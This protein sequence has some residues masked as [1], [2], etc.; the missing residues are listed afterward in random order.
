MG[1]DPKR[2]LLIGVVLPKT[3]DLDHEESLEELEELAFN[4]G[5]QVQETLLVKVRKPQA[6][7]L[8][9]PG[10]ANEI[11]N[12]AK[13]LKCGSILFDEPLMPSQQRNWESTSE[14]NVIDRQEVILDIFADRAQTREAVLQVELARLQYELPRM[15]RL[16]THLDRQRGGGAVQRGEGEAQIEIDQRLIRKRIAK[17]KS[18]LKQV[19]KRRGIQRKQRMKVPVPSFAIVGYTNA[20]KSTLLNCLTGSD[21]LA[22]DKLFATLDPTSRKLTL[23]SGRIIVGT[24][25]VGF[26]NRLPHRLIQA[27]KATL[28]EA[29]VADFLVHVLDSSNPAVEVHLKTTLEVLEELGAEGKPRIT[30]FNKTDLVEDPVCLR[31]LGKLVPGALSVS[32][33]TAEGVDGLLSRMDEALRESPVLSELVVPY[34]HYDL[35]AQLHELGCIQEE[36]NLDHGIRILARDI[37]AAYRERLN[38][39]MRQSSGP[40]GGADSSIN[41]S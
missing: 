21:V 10:K 20:G 16:W 28:E 13:S 31:Q 6:R 27:F 34:K 15:K 30:V 23:P 40:Q 41:V 32:C 12:L 18:E 35:I 33:K 25:T 1:Y 4:L 19:E 29:L 8:T 17:V 9:G 7:F 11:I 39:F 36:K 3:Q 38:G 5:Y 24:D 37:P 14:L 26:V 2:A 22:A